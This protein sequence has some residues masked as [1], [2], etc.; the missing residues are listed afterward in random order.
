M[1][2]PNDKRPRVHVL[3]YLLAAPVVAL[4]GFPIY[5]MVNTALTSEEVLFSRKQDLFPTGFHFGELTTQLARVPVLGMLGNSA[6]VAVGTAA[7][8]VALAL[9]AAYALSRFRFRGKALA[10]FLLFA[11]QMVPAGIYL[12]PI[13]T[14]LLAIGLL[15]NLWGLVLVNTT[16]ALPVSTFIIKAGL[17]AIP[18]E[19]DEAARIDNCPRFGILTTVL[20]PLVLPSIA[21]A[22]ILAFFVA[23][24]ELMFA[25]TYINTQSLWPA[26]VWLSALTTDP[27][28]GLPAVMTVSVLYSIPAIVFFHLVQRRVVSGLTA[29]AV[30]G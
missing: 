22:A 2:N 6:L 24:G 14:M 21:S 5:W 28:V 27:A 4:S 18:V 10:A 7:L 16:F 8:T 9:L 11:T 29:G 19:I 13:Y 3:V 25:A 15:D 23:W 17:D 26:A 30:K 12:I 20:V 1:K